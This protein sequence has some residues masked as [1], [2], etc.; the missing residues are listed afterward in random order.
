MVFKLF[1]S[2]TCGFDATIGIVILVIVGSK[3]INELETFLESVILP[4]TIK[5]TEVFIDGS[6]PLLQTFHDLMQPFL[7]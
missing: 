6:N 5:L 1:V 7:P 4:T 2:N 3:L